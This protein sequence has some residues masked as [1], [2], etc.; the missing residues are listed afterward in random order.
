MEQKKISLYAITALCVCVG[1]VIGAFSAR[2]F[3]SETKEHLTIERS[4][5][6]REAPSTFADITSLN[7]IDKLTV[8]EKADFTKASQELPTVIRLTEDLTI[9]DN[10]TK[11]RYQL[12][13]ESYFRVKATEKHAYQISATTNKGNNVE[14]LIEKKYAIPLEAG[15]W[16]KVQDKKGK[17]GWVKIK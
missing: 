2:R 14:L 17:A 13:A 1:I 8:L 10:A 11:Q 3:F 9:T 6:V 16:K 4:T 15:L 12:K 5:P 7:K